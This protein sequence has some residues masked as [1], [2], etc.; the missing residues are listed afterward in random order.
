MV[1]GQGHVPDLPHFDLYASYGTP[2]TD[3]PDD[4][5]VRPSA[6]GRMGGVTRVERSTSVSLARV[7]WAVVVETWH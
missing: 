2:I 7:F 6:G 5:H 4:R 1:P 3:G